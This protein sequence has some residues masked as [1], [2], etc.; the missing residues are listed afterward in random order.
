MKIVLISGSSRAGSQ[1]IKV[2]RWLEQHLKDLNVETEVL[3]LHKTALPLQHEEIWGEI[4]TDPT[5][6]KVREILDSADGFV[7]VS[8]EWNGMVPPSLKNLFVYVKHTMANKPAYL[9]AVSA[10]R[11]GA[12]PIAELRMNSAKNSFVNYIPEHL[13]IRGAE[14]F[15]NDLALDS[16]DKDD[17]YV[18]HRAMY[19]LKL[20][21][22]Y[23]KALEQVRAS[24]V[25]DYES[26]TNGM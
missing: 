19:G 4:N 13:V 18:K 16:G 26:Y 25:I 22:E 20:L 24:G 10:Y 7:V 11:G 15:M 17:Q 23:T 2:T 14:D 1:S 5:A 8:A 3:D 9:V 6:V 12:Y 21:V